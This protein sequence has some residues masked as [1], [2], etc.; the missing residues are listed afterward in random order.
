MRAQ[1]LPHHE[2]LTLAYARLH[3]SEGAASAARTLLE[4]LVAARPTPLA[5]IH[6]MRLARRSEGAAAS[7]Q[8]FALAR[9]AEGCTWQVYAAAAQ[10]EY[11]MRATAPSATSDADEDEPT[12]IAKRILILAL[13]RYEGVVPLISHAVA[14]FVAQRDVTNARAVLEVQLPHVA[15]S[16]SKEIWKAYLDLEMRY[17][18]PASVRARPAGAPRPLPLRAPPELTWPCA[19]E[20]RQV[21][22]VEER[23]AASHPHLRAGSLYQLAAIHAYA[24]LWPGDYDTLADLAEEPPPVGGPGALGGA[25]GGGGGSAL[26]GGAVGSAGVGGSVK[27]VPN[28]SACVEYTGQD[29]DIEPKVVV[30]SD[31]GAAGYAPTLPILIDELLQ[32]SA[33]R[34][35]A[36][37]KP[38]VTAEDATR[39]CAPA[40]PR[41]RAANSRHAASV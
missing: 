10:L 35:S 36:A 33:L 11:E 7:R 19:G 1:V 2:V 31:G 13:D 28:L 27:V 30:A 18:T 37:A 40:H 9:R 39:L 38:T 16:A 20:R 26:G 41:A 8:V 21:R 17:G 14:F 23:R 4:A 22:A 15:P 34:T 32:T 12:A 24:G 5:Y 6:L 25:L 3:E 29:L